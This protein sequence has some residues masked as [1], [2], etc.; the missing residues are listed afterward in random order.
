MIAILSTAPASMRSSI[1]SSPRTLRL[2]VA[3]ITNGQRHK[4]R[5]AIPSNHDHLAF[6]GKRFALDLRPQPGVIERR[7]GHALSGLDAC[8]WKRMIGAAGR[9]MGAD[10]KCGA[11]QE[12]AWGE[13]SDVNKMRVHSTVTRRAPEAMKSIG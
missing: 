10:A 5:S 6:A 2:Y 4:G 1:R 8:S 11:G 12:T 7:Q 9:H 3:D 13:P